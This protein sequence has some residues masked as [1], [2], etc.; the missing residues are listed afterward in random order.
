VVIPEE[1]RDTRLPDRLALE[2]EGIL[3]WVVDG[4][5]QWQE[6]GLAEPEQ[7]IAAT[8][9][10]RSESDMLGLFLSERCY[11]GGGQYAHVRSA[12]LF[13]AWEHW[14]RRENV[15]A[16]TH[17][18]FSRSLIDKGY[19]PPKKSDGIMRWHGP[20]LLAEEGSDE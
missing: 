19:G 10:F 14:C 13:A 3:T 20:A 17:T 12:E 15:E 6:Q 11:V 2:A 1:E 5:R 18:A 9:T 7:V 16:G 8:S 4:Y